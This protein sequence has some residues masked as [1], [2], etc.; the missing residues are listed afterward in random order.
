M[1]LELAVLD[2]HESGLRFGGTWLERITGIRGGDY[3]DKNSSLVGGE[4]RF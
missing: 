3:R 2:K 4:I 1:K